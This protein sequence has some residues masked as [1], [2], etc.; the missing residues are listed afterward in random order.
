MGKDKK[1]MLIS[2]L[3]SYIDKEKSIDLGKK[4]EYLKFYLK[5]RKDNPR[6]SHVLY[7]TDLDHFKKSDTLFESMRNP[8][9]QSSAFTELNFRAKNRTSV[10]DYYLGNSKPIQEESIENQTNSKNLTKSFGNE[11]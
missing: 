6:T 10:E 9:H 7:L 8:S 4:I 5:R 2:S 3:N 1:L 11:I